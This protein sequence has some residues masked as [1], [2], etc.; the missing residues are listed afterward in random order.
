MCMKEKTV[1][2]I[3]FTC[4]Q[5]GMTSRCQP[6]A[7]VH[8]LCSFNIWKQLFIIITTIFI[9]SGRVLRPPMRRKKE[10]FFIMHV[11]KKF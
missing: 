10:G 9:N 8:G 2:L 3:F 11:E 7:L 1:E 4:V 5:P 6:T